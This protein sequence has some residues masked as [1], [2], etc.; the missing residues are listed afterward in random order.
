MATTTL[1]PAQRSTNTD[2]RPPARFVDP[3]A[4]ICPGCGEQVRCAPPGYWRVADGLPVPQFSHHDATALCR[5]PAGAVADP[6][7]AT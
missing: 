6:I 4:L 2:A 7:E 3:E 1:I 5:T